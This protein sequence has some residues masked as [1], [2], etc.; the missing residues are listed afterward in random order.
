MYRRNVD[1]NLRKLS[2]A[3]D[4]G[5]IPPTQF[6]SAL[7]RSGTG[8]EILQV[9]ERPHTANCHIDLRLSDPDSV[10]GPW[11]L[12]DILL[13]FVTQ[14]LAIQFPNPDQDYDGHF[15]PV[16]SEEVYAVCPELRTL[17]ADLAG[18]SSFLMSYDDS[19]APQFVLTI[20][21]A[22]GTQWYNRRD[23]VLERY[24][25]LYQLFGSI[26]AVLHHDGNA[27]SEN[28]PMGTHQLQVLS[29]EPF[30]F[31]GWIN[32]REDYL[33]LLTLGVSFTALRH[34]VDQWKNH[35]FHLMRTS[36]DW[37]SYYKD[38]IRPCYFEQ[39][40]GPVN[41][42]CLGIA[43]KEGSGNP[44]GTRVGSTALLQVET[45]DD[46]R[47]LLTWIWIFNGNPLGMGGSGL[48]DEEG[49]IQILMAH[50]D[51]VIQLA[52]DEDWHHISVSAGNYMQ[53]VR[54]LTLRE[55]QNQD[56]TIKKI[57]WLD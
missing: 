52:Q 57:V 16:P 23:V 17:L 8:V 1:E 35:L 12:D 21:L 47:D 30:R 24:A 48:P 2:R 26:G 32:L 25:F 15:Y 18:I 31:A 43:I 34:N 22:I 38:S 46:P 36:P 28:L 45:V 5:Q 20:D 6:A 37:P 50:R 55:A 39:Q 7:L 10:L 49:D 54:E 40:R 13:P 53:Y 3:Y 11:D 9:I 33:P 44:P 51:G 42:L 14:K 41:G 4:A 19:L 56:A 27:I 29:D